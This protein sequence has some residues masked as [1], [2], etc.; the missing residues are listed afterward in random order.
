WKSV[1]K[2][3]ARYDEK[4][5]MHVQA[6]H[7]RL[8]PGEAIAAQAQP[9][10]AARGLSIDPGDPRLVPAIE[11]VRQRAQTLAEVADMI[12]YYFREPP[13]MDEKAAKKFLVPSAKANLAS[14]RE[15]V[16]E[17]EPFEVA[18]LEAKTNAWMAEKGLTFKDYA[19]A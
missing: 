11:S 12:D 8:L 17:V 19:Q 1:G 7:L 9:F 16:G 10:I 18:S 13:I 14:F 6:H 3:G 5:F 15:L 2:E 4:K